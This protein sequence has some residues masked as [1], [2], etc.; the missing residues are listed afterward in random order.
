[1]AYRPS[2][3]GNK[4]VNVKAAIQIF[5]KNATVTP[6]TKTNLVVSE[7]RRKFAM[8]CSMGESKQPLESAEAKKE[9]KYERVIFKR[10]ATLVRVTLECEEVCNEDKTSQ[11]AD[12]EVNS[13]CHQA[14]AK[15]L[16]NI[17]EEENENFC[18]KIDK[19][20][21]SYGVQA[22]SGKNLTVVAVKQGSVRSETENNQT[23]TKPTVPIKKVTKE[24]I[25]T[26]V[27]FS[28]IKNNDSKCVKET[29]KPESICDTARNAC[30]TENTLVRQDNLPCP[31]NSSAMLESSVKR[32]H[33][34]Q[35]SENLQKGDKE[36]VVPNRSFLWG[37]SV[38]GTNQYTSVPATNQSPLIA[39]SNQTTSV[40]NIDQ[41][42]SVP[43]TNQ[44]TS[45]AISNQTTSVPN[46]DQLT[47]VPG[48]NQPTSVPLVVTKNYE[49][50]QGDNFA[51]VT[52][53]STDDF[54][55]DVYP[56][57]AV[58]SSGTSSKHLYSVVQPQDDDVYDDVG[59]P[60]NEEKQCAGSTAFVAAVR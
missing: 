34:T 5:E 43:S 40:P 53:S 6:S 39:I 1:M 56:P 25:H 29:C 20:L 37:A 51:K 22:K 48:T 21:K 41:L 57:S 31:Q 49:S 23:K 24:L 33:A 60:T 7:D 28:K 27:P 15:F 32:L 14:T 35:E 52:I 10:D 12:G 11:K 58:C 47:S 4:S 38:P 46:T 30:M 3:A 50:V 13:Q 8:N 45:N 16:P 2:A 55:D 54:Y 9:P 44:S 18:V 42:T 36:S 26:N 19:D 17:C 59:P